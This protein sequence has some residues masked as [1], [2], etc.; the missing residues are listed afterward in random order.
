MYLV[1]LVEGQFPS[2]ISI[3]N[4]KK[5]NP[6]LMEEEV[7]LFYVGVTRAKERL[8]LL[9]AKYSNGQKIKDSRFIKSFLEKYKFQKFETETSPNTFDV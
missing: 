1:D 7:R 4:N 3:N 6:K 5:G 8:E 2:S 9:S